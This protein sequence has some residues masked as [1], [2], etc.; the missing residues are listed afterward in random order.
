MIIPKEELVAFGESDLVRFFEERSARRVM[1]FF[2]LTDMHQIIKKP[3]TDF[4]DKTVIGLEQNL[5]AYKSLKEAKILDNTCKI[6]SSKLKPSYFDIRT[7]E[8]YPQNVDSSLNGNYS[9]NEDLPIGSISIKSKQVPCP[10]SL[11]NGLVG[12]LD[13]FIEKTS[14]KT[15]IVDISEKMIAF[16]K[17][18]SLSPDKDEIEHYKNTKIKT[19]LYPG[20]VDRR[21]TRWY[22]RVIALQ[23]PETELE[24][25]FVIV[26]NL[27]RKLKMTNHYFFNQYEEKN[28]FKHETV[29]DLILD[30]SKR[31]NWHMF[32]DSLGTSSGGFREKISQLYN[33]ILE[34]AEYQFSANK[35][36][37]LG[38][39]T[40]LVRAVKF[41]DYNQTF[42]NEWKIS[43]IKPI[44]CMAK[45][46]MRKQESD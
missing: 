36:N 5:L 41:I 4:Y 17:N 21:I 11:F 19:T 32:R 9:S 10:F 42:N 34:T 1:Y 26:E 20:E 6:V 45:E 14:E 28:N 15:V 37:Y 24:K 23:K 8:G 18:T 29:E 25:E 35:E 38:K 12:N 43:D 3:L 2:N 33:A 30:M 31:E 40:D 39:Y 46:I 16:L 22:E 13:V 7:K 44:D 27:Q